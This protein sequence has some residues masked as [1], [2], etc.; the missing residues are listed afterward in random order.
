MSAIDRGQ[1]TVRQKLPQPSRRLPRL[2]RRQIRGGHAHHRIGIVGLD[3]E[4]PFSEL[5]R[6]GV[7]APKRGDCRESGERSHVRFALQGLL[8]TAARFFNPPQ[9]Q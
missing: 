7:I 9:R 3:L 6:F 1:T 5:A 2:L 4:H 8:E